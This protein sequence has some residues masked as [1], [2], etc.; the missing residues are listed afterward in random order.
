M[1]AE[2]ATKTESMTSEQTNQVSE[3][4]FQV[5]VIVEETRTN[6]VQLHRQQNTEWIPNDGN[7]ISLKNLDLGLEFLSILRQDFP[8]C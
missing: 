7:N 3:C 5:V 1:L 4:E 8:R 2:T 6:V